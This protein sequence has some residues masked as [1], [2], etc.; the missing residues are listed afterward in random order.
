VE[1]DAA[2]RLLAK[3]RQFVERELDEEERALFGALVAPGVAKAYT[4]SEVEG[5]TLTSWGPEALPEALT[6]ALREQGVRLVGL[7]P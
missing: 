6:A 7:D 1:S 5:F 3:L 4:E 2:H